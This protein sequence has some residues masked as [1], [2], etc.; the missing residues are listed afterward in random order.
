MMAAFGALASRVF[1]PV[2]SALPRW[3]PWAIAAACVVAATWFRADAVAARSEIADAAARA[4]RR[5]TDYVADRVATETEAVRRSERALADRRV[6][7]ATTKERIRHAL[8]SDDAALAPV[9]HDALGRLRLGSAGG[10][11][12]RPGAP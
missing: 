7:D 3:L 8:D 9:L 10:G 11:A 5:W 12:A 6:A 2:L 1:A 4:E